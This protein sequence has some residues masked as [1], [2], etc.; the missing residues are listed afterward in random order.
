MTHNSEDPVAHKYKEVLEGSVLV[1][2]YGERPTLTHCQNTAQYKF[3]DPQLGPQQP[4][5][6]PSFEAYLISDDVKVCRLRLQLLRMRQLTHG[7]WLLLLSDGIVATWVFA[8]DSVEFSLSYSIFVHDPTYSAKDILLSTVMVCL[9]KSEVV[10]GVVGVRVL[11]ILIEDALVPNFEDI[12]EQNKTATLNTYLFHMP[13]CLAFKDSDNYQQFVDSYGVGMTDDPQGVGSVSAAKSILCAYVKFLRSSCIFGRPK[14]CPATMPSVMGVVSTHVLS[15]S[16]QMP[17]LLS[18]VWPFLD[19]ADLCNLYCTSKSGKGLLYTCGYDPRDTTL[20][21]RLLTRDHTHSTQ[22][23][24]NA[25]QG[26]GHAEDKKH[27]EEMIHHLRNSPLYSEYAVTSLELESTGRY[28]GP[29]V[30]NALTVHHLEFDTSHPEVKHLGLSL[31]VLAEQMELRVALYEDYCWTYDMDDH[32]MFAKN[33]GGGSP[34]SAESAMAEAVNLSPVHNAEMLKKTLHT[35]PLSTGVFANLKQQSLEMRDL[36][37]EISVNCENTMNQNKRIGEYMDKKENLRVTLQICTDQFVHLTRAFYS[38]SVHK[39][40]LHWVGHPLSQ[41]P[42]GMELHDDNLRTAIRDGRTTTQ[43]NENGE[44]TLRATLADLDKSGLVELGILKMSGNCYI[45]VDGVYFVTSERTDP[46][47]TCVIPDERF[48][49]FTAHDGCEKMMISTECESFMEIVT[50][51]LIAR[52]V[53]IPMDSCRPA[54]GESDNI[55]AHCVFSMTILAPQETSF[56]SHISQSTSNMSHAMFSEQKICFEFLACNFVLVKQNEHVEIR[57]DTAKRHVFSHFFDHFL[58]DAHNMLGNWK[59][60]DPDTYPQAMPTLAYPDL[61]APVVTHLQLWID[62]WN[63]EE[64]NS[65][66]ESSEE[67]GSEEEGSD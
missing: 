36:A 59:N 12:T 44:T 48:V 31:A 2:K 23:I 26:R 8:V 46:D 41:K 11:D 57:P 50:D 25:T 16:L 42:D 28:T 33:T 49:T 5:G 39:F 52:Q 19:F 64:E 13:N 43:T 18:L 29:L 62:G 40:G 66:E 24:V 53:Q 47:E 30:S 61:V 58:Q 6:P 38:H 55:L 60:W 22:Q 15:S 7:G 4:Y 65:E 9:F 63:N 20:V 54:P 1:W 37:F 51:M 56:I 67:E 3:F 14:L 45:L 32:V 34:L 35:R 17:T 10:A 27:F 21:D